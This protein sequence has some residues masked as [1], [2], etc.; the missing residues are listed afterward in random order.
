MIWLIGKFDFLIELIITGE[1][2]ME[3]VREDLRQMK[4]RPLLLD[5]LNRTGWKE[6]KAYEFIA[7][8]PLDL[9]VSGVDQWIVVSISNVSMLN[10]S[11]LSIIISFI[12]NDHSQTYQYITITSNHKLFE[13]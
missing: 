9:I 11:L 12:F 5:R 8:A 10:W 1:E 2:S 6:Q 7:A 4:K 13:W 3:F